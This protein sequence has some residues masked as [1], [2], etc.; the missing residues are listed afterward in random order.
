MPK[1]DKTATTESSKCFCRFN[2]PKEE[3]LT[4]VKIND[5]SYGVSMNF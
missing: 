3:L 2:Q 1:K 4:S 5:N